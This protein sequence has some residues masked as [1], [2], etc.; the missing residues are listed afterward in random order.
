MDSFLQF[1]S[2][3]RESFHQEFTTF[4]TQR[5]FTERF[6]RFF[7]GILQYDVVRLQLEDIHVLFGCR[8]IHHGRRIAHPEICPQAVTQELTPNRHVQ[9]KFAGAAWNYSEYAAHVVDHIA[10]NL[11]FFIRLWREDFCNVLES[12]EKLGS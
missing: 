2:L 11:F 3:L 12:P 6:L 9:R 8:P 1:L 7:Q 5:D 4:Y 10:A